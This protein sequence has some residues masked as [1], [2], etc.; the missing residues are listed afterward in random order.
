MFST[1]FRGEAGE[2]SPIFRLLIPINPLPEMVS[3]LEAPVRGTTEKIRTQTAEGKTPG[4][5]EAP[6]SPQPE[7]TPKTEPA[8]QETNDAPL[9]KDEGGEKEKSFW[10]KIKER[11][12]SPKEKT[13]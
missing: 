4:E 7:N 2:Q 1:Q 3:G 6:I 10:S 11:V 8:P 5:P 13:D 12:Q 9:Q